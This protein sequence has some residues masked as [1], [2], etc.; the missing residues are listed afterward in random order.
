MESI[1][2]K[3][4]II[5]KKSNN[6]H[7]AWN[8][9]SI[10][11]QPTDSLL[12]TYTMAR[13]LKTVVIDDEESIIQIILDLCHDSPFVEIIETFSSPKEFLKAAPLLDFDL[14]L[15]DI[16]M[17]EMDGLTL[18][19]MLNNKP[20]IFITDADSKLRNALSLA[21]VDIVTKPILKDRFDKA[22]SK[23]YEL[24]AD[25]L[26]Y[27]LFNVAESKT[28]I[29]LHLPDILLVITDSIDPR[30]KIVFLRNGEKYTIMDC[31]LLRLLDLCPLLIQVNKSEAVS[32]EAI[33]EV[34]HEIATIKNI[35]DTDAPK[36]I[37]IG[38][39]YRK[40]FKER[41]FYKS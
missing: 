15:I 34:E 22:L 33:H 35:Q 18:A 21:P 28:K 26:D 11:A 10:F 29:K 40:S 13:K 30:N 4:Y 3:Q 23:A 2:F 19:Q 37:S 6:Y 7:K 27:E 14:C 5:N 41:L 17:P 9:F 38:R 1:T 32:L 8:I 25:K 16:E 39:I 20:F 31:T 12:N 36:Y 24:F